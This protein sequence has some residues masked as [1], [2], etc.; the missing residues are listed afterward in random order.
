[1]FPRLTSYINFG[2]EGPA[3]GE[4]QIK[5]FRLITSG[6]LLLPPFFLLDKGFISIDIFAVSPHPPVVDLGNPTLKTT[7]S[8]TL[9]FIHIS[10]SLSYCESRPWPRLPPV[11]HASPPRVCPAGL[12]DLSASHVYF[13]SRLTLSLFLS[14]CSLIV[15]CFLITRASA[16]PKGRKAK[17][18]P[19]PSP[20]LS[21][22]G[23]QFHS[24]CW[25]VTYC[26]LGVDVPGG[27]GE[28]RHS[29]DQ[30]LVLSRMG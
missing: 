4:T 3:A 1:M 15:V 11:S 28:T 8:K 27:P 2:L 7:E 20:P 26:T 25:L 14:F 16:I 5:D 12:S 9:G 18:S 22:W 21:L 17:V 24:G 23:L 13:P 29:P 6:A 30:P 19:S 10:L